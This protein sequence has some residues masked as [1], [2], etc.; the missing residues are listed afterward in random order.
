MQRCNCEDEKC[1]PDGDCYKR[2][3]V[4]EPLYWVFAYGVPEVLCAACF[5]HAVEIH[6]SQIELRGTLS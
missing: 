3:S 4:K 5:R 2:N 1:H 6:G